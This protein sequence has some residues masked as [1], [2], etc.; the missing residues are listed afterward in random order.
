MILP[1]ATGDTSAF[2][3]D[4][5]L[6]SKAEREAKA[7]Q[8]VQTTFA[9]FPWITE[10]LTAYEA[11]KEPEAQFVKAVDKIVTLWIDY[12]DG[13]EYYR[14]RKMP[15]QHFI[16]HLVVVRKKAALHNEALRYWDEVYEKILSTPG[17]FYQEN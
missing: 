6:G 17:Y 15:K 5:W 1:S 10:T 8:K 4:A 11:Q 9:H 3:D 7:L 12:L 2:A 16:D 14:E 13:G